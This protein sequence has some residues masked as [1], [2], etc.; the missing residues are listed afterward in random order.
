MLGSAER[1]GAFVKELQSFAAHT[2]FEFNDVTKASQKFLAFGFTA[3]QIIPTLT[4]VGDAA[5]G[6]GAGQDGVNRL[7]IALGQIA[8]KGK[9]ASQEMS[10]LQNLVFLPAAFG[11]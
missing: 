1:A 3:E 9:L 4:A 8:A 6:V 7:T 10:R 11:G 2:P 5:A